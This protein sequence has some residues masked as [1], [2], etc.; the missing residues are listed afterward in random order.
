[1]FYVNSAFTKDFF[2]PECAGT[3]SPR[4]DL[5]FVQTVLPNAEITLQLT[6]SVGDNNYAHELRL[7][8]SSD[9]PGITT[10]ACRLASDKTPI[11][12]RNSYSVAQKVYYFVQS[13]MEGNIGSRFQLSWAL[14][15][16]KPELRLGLCRTL[17]GSKVDDSGFCKNSVCSLRVKFDL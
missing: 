16:A 11:V 9:C 13:G 17:M 7:G 12:W 14:T 5:V 8:G 1:M 6:A 2:E 4:P 10:L 3:S 15:G